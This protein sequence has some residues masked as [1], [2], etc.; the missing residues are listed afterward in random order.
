[1]GKKSENNGEKVGNYGEKVG[2]FS[3]NSLID[4]VI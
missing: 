3:L 1:M 4:R 2:D